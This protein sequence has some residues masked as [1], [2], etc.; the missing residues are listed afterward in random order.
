MIYLR[1]GSK[2]GFIKTVLVTSKAKVLFVHLLGPYLE[3]N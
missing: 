1:F 2:S 3:Q